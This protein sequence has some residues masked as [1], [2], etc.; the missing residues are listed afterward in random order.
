MDIPSTPAHHVASTV[1]KAIPPISALLFLWYF[2]LASYVLSI[3]PITG[4][5]EAAAGGVF[6][7]TAG[8]VLAHLVPPLYY[9]LVDF[10]S[11][12]LGDVF[13]MWMTA[14]YDIGV[15]ATFMAMGLHLTLLHGYATVTFVGD[16]VPVTPSVLFGLGAL[17]MHR[18]LTQTK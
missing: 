4:P 6:V 13:E 5:W 11:R 18:M 2:G 12:F 3:L 17:F 1:V 8:V 15:P 10:I 16:A 14:T 7:F 9:L